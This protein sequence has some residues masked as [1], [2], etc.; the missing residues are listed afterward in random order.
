[1]IS[2]SQLG[3]PSSP[4]GF[5]AVYSTCSTVWPLA[6]RR[7]VTSAGRKGSCWA[8]RNLFTEL[9]VA[10]SR[11][12]PAGAGE[13]TVYAGGR[14]LRLPSWLPRKALDT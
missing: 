7:G 2:L 3:A 9:S 14:C 4:S 12:R 11:P 13:C 8:S 1:M 6:S 10:A 5:G